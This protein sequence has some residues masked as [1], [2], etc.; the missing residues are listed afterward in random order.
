MDAQTPVRQMLFAMKSNL[1]PAL[2]IALIAACGSKVEAK[3]DVASSGASGNFNSYLADTKSK[4]PT[5]D[6][7]LAG[8][9]GYVKDEVKLYLCESGNWEALAFERGATGPS[10]ATGAQGAPGRSAVAHFLS[11]STPVGAG[12][13]C[14]YSG[15][16][17]EAGLDG[18]D[19][20]ML[21]ATEIGSRLHV[22]EGSINAIAREQFLLHVYDVGLVQTLYYCNANPVGNYVGG[23]G[24]GWIANGTTIVTNAHV[25]PRTSTESCN[26]SNQALALTGIKVYFPKLGLPAESM[27]RKGLPHAGGPVPDTTDSFDVV[28]LDA[29]DRT[30]E[31][32]GASTR[33]QAFPA[34]AMNCLGSTTRSHW[35]RALRCRRFF[36]GSPA[37]LTRVRILDRVIMQTRTA[38]P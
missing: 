29:I 21:D 11:R 2:V 27:L 22:C 32:V 17:V 19:N 4:L 5:C 13:D 25:V 18:N 6:G 7:S 1:A 30:P 20:S 24:T 15:T 31:T 8:S 3:S 9:L 12:E 36:K 10:G 37:T 16:R 23:L 33:F 35:V 28:T 26:G 14:K 38:A 34:W